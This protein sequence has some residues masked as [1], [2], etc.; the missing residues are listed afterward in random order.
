MLKDK[1]SGKSPA[2]NAKVDP[3]TGDNLSVDPMLS[4]NDSNRYQKIPGNSIAIFP[5]R[6]NERRIQKG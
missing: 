4:I 3:K 6:Y 2:F 5:V 1:L